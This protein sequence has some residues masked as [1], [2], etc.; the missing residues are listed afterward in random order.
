MA[1]FVGRI[2]T[3]INYATGKAEKTELDEQ[4]VLQTIRYEHFRDDADALQGKLADILVNPNS[5]TCAE[6]LAEA[7]AQMSAHVDKSYGLNGDAANLAEC[8]RAIG[9]A[10]KEIVPTIRE[11]VVTP[12]QKFLKTEVVEFK[13]AKGQLDTA[14]LDMDGCRSKRAR[15]QSP[16]PSVKAELERKEEEA[17]QT[18][19]TKLEE[20]KAIANQLGSHQ[21]NQEQIL[22]TFATTLLEYHKAAAEKINEYLQT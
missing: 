2:G 10:Q 12:M 8:L 5:L 16:D 11:N 7:M 20:F 9:R 21:N 1:R 6:K 19:E 22:K 17:R 15:S 13:K 18:F 14:I 4:T 3:K